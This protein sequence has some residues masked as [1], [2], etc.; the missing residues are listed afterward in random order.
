M[1]L[2]LFFFLFIVALWNILVLQVPFLFLLWVL[3]DEVLFVFRPGEEQLLCRLD[4]ETRFRHWKEEEAKG[5]SDD[6]RDTTQSTQE[7]YDIEYFPLVYQLLGCKV[8]L[9]LTH[10]IWIFLLNCRL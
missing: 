6:A 3:I 1:S 7:S 10:E 4:D 9:G 2:R 5:E 8:D